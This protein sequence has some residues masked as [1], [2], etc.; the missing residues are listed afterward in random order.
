MTHPKLLDR[1]IDP[2][3]PSNG[4]V[5]SKGR[6]GTA[7]L[8]VVCLIIAAIAWV[9]GLSQTPA[10]HQERQVAG[11]VDAAPQYPVSGYFISASNDDVFNR[12]KLAEIKKLGGDTVITFGTLLKPVSPADLPLDCIVERKSCGQLLNDKLRVNRYF[13]YSDGSRWGSPALKCPQDKEVA[14]G[15]KLFT[16]LV[17][18]VEGKGCSSSSGTYDVIVVGGSSRNSDDPATSL[19]SAATELGMQ[20]FAGLPSPVKRTDVDYL[21][22]LTYQRT[23]VA[24]TERFLEYQANVNNVAGLAGF[25]HHTEMPLTNSDVFQPILNLYTLQNQA[26]HRVFPTRSA[27]ISPYLD[28]RRNSPSITLDAARKGALRIAETSAGVPLNVAIQ[29]GMGTGKAAAFTPAEAQASVD[30]YAESVVGK[31]TWESKYTAPISAY[32]D[33]AA[34]GL[35]QSQAVLWANLEGMAP[36]T[37]SNACGNSLRGQ[38]TKTRIDRQ[39][40]QLYRATR[41]ISFMWD[42]YYTCVGAGTPLKSQVES[43]IDAPVVTS[44]TFQAGAGKVEIA[45]FN[46]SGGKATIA[47]TTASGQRKQVSAEPSLTNPSLGKQLG[48]HPQLEMI[49]VEVGP[50]TLKPSQNPLINVTNRWGAGVSYVSSPNG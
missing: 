31:G 10:D 19:A 23:L 35:S 42:S 26:I 49:T 3:L 14:T 18:P 34:E 46:I 5:A 20:Y 29:D 21:P 4:P 13:T 25:Y 11:D 36:A 9:T 22:D 32:M 6:R 37:G 47:W 33:A 27:V 2:R 24:F 1:D 15:E 12:N 7:L 39:L 40:Q 16:I 48:L 17:V 43:G 44:A 50:T 38:T 45:G 41:V 8:C 28:T 30:K